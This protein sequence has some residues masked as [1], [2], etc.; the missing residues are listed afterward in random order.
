MNHLL[1]HRSGRVRQFNRFQSEI[2]RQKLVTDRRRVQLQ[3][4]RLKRGMIRV[5]GCNRGAG[6]LDSMGLGDAVSYTH[7]M[8]LQIAV[9]TTIRICPLA[10]LNS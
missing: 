3:C 10:A 5:A 6:V 2:G 9:S 7:L 1:L 4:F 8:K